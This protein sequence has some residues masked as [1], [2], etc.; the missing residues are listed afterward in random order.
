[1]KGGQSSGGTGG[2]A[3]MPAWF[4]M[5][6]QYFPQMFGGGGGYGGGASSYAQGGAMSGANPYGGAGGGPPSYTGPPRDQPLAPPPG[7][8]PDPGGASGGVM[9]PPTPTPPAQPP[10]LLGGMPD[11][12]GMQYGHTMPQGLM[13]NTGAP[14]PGQWFN[15][16][17]GVPGVYP[18]S[19]QAG[20]VIGSGGTM[21]QSGQAQRYGV[22]YGLFGGSYG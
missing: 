19:G 10:G 20:G 2:Q 1:M 5:A 7:A 16:G 21:A 3:G 9:T 11:A 15:R 17:Y 13:S 6:Q 12:S 8:M 22:P 18:P 4:G 14:S